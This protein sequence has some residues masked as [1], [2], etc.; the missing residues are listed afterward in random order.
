MSWLMLDVMFL[1]VVSTAFGRPMY[2]KW[3]IS[4]RAN[5]AREFEHDIESNVSI[6]LRRKN[7]ST[8]SPR[9]FWVNI[10]IKSLNLKKL[11]LSPNFLAIRLG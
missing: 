5:G 6:Y 10:L 11:N 3:I 1:V 8:E 9:M 4:G 2:G 7:E